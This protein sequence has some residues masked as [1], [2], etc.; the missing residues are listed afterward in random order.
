MNR[1]SDLETVTDLRQWFQGSVHEAMHRNALSAGRLTE[2]YVADL[3]VQYSRSERLYEVTEEGSG[4]KPLAFMY[5]DAMESPSEEVRRQNLQRLGDIA[6]FIAGY[7]A[8]SL[9]RKSVDVDYYAG[10]G[11]A[12]YNSLAETPPRNFDALEVNEVFRELAEKFTAFMDVLAEVGHM[13][14][15]NGDQ[16]I[17]RLY[18]T[19]MHTGSP[20]ARRKLEAMGVIPNESSTS[21]RHH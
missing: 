15:G 17:L 20:R 8:E 10:M 6:L 21:R 18:E 16:S 9:S 13:A 12:A 4:L 1:R 11:G 7:F 3:L 2:R 19:W 14:H 5:Q